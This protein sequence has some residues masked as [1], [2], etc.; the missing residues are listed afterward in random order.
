MS[1]STASATFEINSSQ[2]TGSCAPGMGRV[3][4]CSITAP[5]VSKLM[6]AVRKFVPP[7]SMTTAFSPRGSFP[8]DER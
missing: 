2:V 7:A 5:F 8:A 1:G 6:T 4:C 3:F